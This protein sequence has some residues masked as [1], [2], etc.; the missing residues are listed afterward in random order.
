MIE[1]QSMCRTRA[2]IVTGQ[3][4]SVVAKRLHDL[5]LILGHSPERVIDM[6]GATIGGTDAV[7]VT[8]EVR[9]HDVE[10][11]RQA[12][13]DFVPGGVRERIAMQQ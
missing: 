5:D 7:A 2:T 6:V 4:K 8:S 12:I 9:R 11:P 1:C 13:G 3:K 10:S